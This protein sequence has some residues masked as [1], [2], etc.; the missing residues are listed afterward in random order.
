MNDALEQTI[1]NELNNRIAN[2]KSRIESPTDVFL[3]YFDGKLLRSDINPKFIFFVDN[4]FEG[5]YIHDYS[6]MLINLKEE[7]KY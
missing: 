2:I 1:T 7:N 5:E 6:N 3:D 4:Y